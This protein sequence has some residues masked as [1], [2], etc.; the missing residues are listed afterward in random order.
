MATIRA[1]LL[2][3]IDILKALPNG[4]FFD[5]TVTGL[6]F[7]ADSQ[8]KVKELRQCL[9]HVIWE[10]KYNSCCKWWEYCAKINNLTLKIYA[11]KE[12]PPTC[13]AIYE[14]R[15]VQSKVPIKFETRMIKEKVI[16]G[17]DC[18]KK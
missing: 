10:K 2:E 9:P 3:G 16:I 12:N 17:W 5:T 18:G 15:E 13:K 4:T 8:A 11:V 14:E 7:Q 6:E 1:S